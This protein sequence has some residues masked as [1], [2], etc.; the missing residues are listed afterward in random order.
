MLARDFIINA[1][2]DFH[3]R[4]FTRAVYPDQANFSVGVERQM[5]IFKD[6]LITEFLR[7]TLHMITELT[8]HGALLSSKGISR[9]RYAAAR[10]KLQ[11]NR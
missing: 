4:G 6:G 10:Q 7:Q 1:R 2:H 11:A 9:A 3:E 5:H 8:G